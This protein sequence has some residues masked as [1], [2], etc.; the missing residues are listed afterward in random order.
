MQSKSTAIAAAGALPVIILIDPQLG[1]N[2]GMVARAMDNCG[3]KKLILLYLAM[4]KE[5]EDNK[6][7]AENQHLKLR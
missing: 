4:S 3:L 5:K 6:K 2:I 7:E 1:E